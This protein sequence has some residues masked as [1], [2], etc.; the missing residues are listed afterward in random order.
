MG[1]VNNSAIE[2]TDI[3]GVQNKKKLIQATLN[4]NQF[5]IS[6][7]SL[8]YGH[9]HKY[10]PHKLRNNNNHCSS[11]FWRDFLG[12]VVLFFLTNCFWDFIPNFTP[13]SWKGMALLCQSWKCIKNLLPV[14]DRILDE[15]TEST[16][17]KRS[18][19]LGDA[20]LLWISY[21]RR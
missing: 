21:M 1:T 18:S 20:L 3:T 11:P 14:A 4:D 12:R 9:H 7:L 13:K 15:C 8:G 19:K 6:N 5:T 2:Y 17:M 16:W 10:Y